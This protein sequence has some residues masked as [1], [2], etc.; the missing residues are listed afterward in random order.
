MN[1]AR[2]IVRSSK[3]RS[4][5]FAESVHEASVDDDVTSSGDARDFHITRLQHD[6]LR[7]LGFPFHR[8]L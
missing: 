8:Q 1:M 6:R 2:I 7:Q 4:A 3:T 5:A